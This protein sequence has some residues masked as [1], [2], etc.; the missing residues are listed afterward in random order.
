MEQL[1]QKARAGDPE[2]FVLLM[3]QQE[4]ALYRIAL[5]YFSDPMDVE[6]VLSETVLA[7]WERLDTLRQPQYFKSWLIRILINKCN[8][9]FRRR[10]RLVPLEGT[11][12]PAVTMEP[13][14]DLSA[15]LGGLSRETRLVLLLY[16]SQG[17]KTREIAKLLD[18]P[19]GTVTSRLKR[20][21]DAL[22]RR[23]AGEEERK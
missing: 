16:Y 6:D 18:L 2:A 1:L 17:Y 19:H 7:C 5:G 21:R 23:L 13:E 3:R 9:Q 8:D 14:D 12:E 20:G 4:Q 10:K 15:L 11:P 22:A